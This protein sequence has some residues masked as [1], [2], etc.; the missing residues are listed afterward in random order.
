MRNLIAKTGPENMNQDNYFLDKLSPDR[1]FPHVAVC[2]KI[3]A[4][5]TKAGGKS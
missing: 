1:N 2:G 5:F 4:L 3:S